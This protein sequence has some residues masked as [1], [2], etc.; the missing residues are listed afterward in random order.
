MSYKTSGIDLHMQPNGQNIVNKTY[1]F[2]TKNMS[3]VFLLPNNLNISGLKIPLLPLACYPIRIT[4]RDMYGYTIQDAKEIQIFKPKDNG[5][6]V[7]FKDIDNFCRYTSELKLKVYMQLDF[8]S[9]PPI[10]SKMEFITN[11]SC[12]MM[13]SPVYFAGAWLADSMPDIFFSYF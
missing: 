10:G 8:N 4:L 12:P 9:N 5:N 11:T 1:N 6:V 7:L 13:C 2:L 3:Q